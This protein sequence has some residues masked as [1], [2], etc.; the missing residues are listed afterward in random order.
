[1]SQLNKWTESRK[2]TFAVAYIG[3]LLILLAMC[4]YLFI[5]KNQA[6][7]EHQVVAVSMQKTIDSMN[8][9]HTTLQNDFNAASAKIDR[10][11]SQ[12]LRLDSSMHARQAEMRKLQHRIKTIL[13]DKNATAQELKTAQELIAQLTDKTKEY[14]THIAEL[15]KQNTELTNKNQVLVHEVDSTTTQ[16]VALKKVASVLHTSNLRMVPVHKRKNGKEKE[17]VKAKKVNALK[18]LFDIDEN[19]IAESG[20]KQM[21]VRIV[22]PDGNVLSSAANASGTLTTNAGSPVNYSLMKEVTLAQNEVVK[23]V[24]ID[25]MQDN[26]YKRGNYTIEIYNDGYK[27]GNGRIML[28]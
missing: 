23:D 21:Y 22:G 17:T 24:D 15:E 12:N 28:N 10:L 9:S 16:N 18:I 8:T 20:K 5:S 25:W 27:V 14:E 2:K 1:M 13:D 7:S 6:A 3:S 19:K 26:D 4:A 11:T